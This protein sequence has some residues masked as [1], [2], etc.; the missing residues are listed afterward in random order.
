MACACCGGD[1]CCT[2]YTPC[3]GKSYPSSLSMDLTP[4]TLDSGD[5]AVSALAVTALGLTIGG[6][7]RSGCLTYEATQ[8]FGDGANNVAAGSL[9][10]TCTG[11]AVA[12][13]RAGMSNGAA[14]SY[15]SGG[16]IHYRWYKNIGTVSGQNVYIVYFNF[17]NPSVSLNTPYVLSPSG[18][19]LNIRRLCD[20]SSTAYQ[21]NT[22]EDF[23]I[24]HF[25]I[26]YV[27]GGTIT[28]G[29]LV[30]GSA[31]SLSYYDDSYLEV[32]L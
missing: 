28:G 32:T 8:A 31:G 10:L 30:G 3:V 17:Q 4:G 19:Q 20:N 18:I 26:N 23:S 12:H 29:E 2:S 22:G 14:L 25:Q 5:S 11:D 9:A 13:C 6:M 7:P 16:S 24:G 1:E 21:L 27:T 15:T